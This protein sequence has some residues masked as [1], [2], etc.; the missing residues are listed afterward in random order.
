MTDDE[1]RKLVRAVLTEMG[2]DVADPNEMQADFVFLRNQRKVSE[3]IGAAGRVAILG[4]V[5]SGIASLIWLGLRAALG[6]DPSS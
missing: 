4:I 1:A 6:G 3:K 2:I 5:L